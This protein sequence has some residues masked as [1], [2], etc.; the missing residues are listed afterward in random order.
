MPFWSKKKSSGNTDYQRARDR[1]DEWMSKFIGLRDADASGYGRCISCGKLVH[2]SEADNGHFI[3]RGHLNT[4]YDEQNCNLQ[5][6]KCNRFDEGNNVGY[7]QGLLK[8]YGQCV[9]QELTLKKHLYRK[10][11]DF[12]YRELIK[13]YKQKVKDLEKQKNG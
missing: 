4:R 6:T 10:Y 13:Y 11:S 5:C 7:M 12:E 8:K 9:V 3:N 2:W 1:A